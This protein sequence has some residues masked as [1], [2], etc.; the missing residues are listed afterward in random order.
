MASKRQDLCPNTQQK[1]LA[2]LKP[3]G[4]T[5]SEDE[6]CPYCVFLIGAHNL[7]APPPQQQAGG[8]GWLRDLTCEGVEAN[9]GPCQD[10][11]AV[12]PCK[13]SLTK[14]DLVAA[15]QPAVGGTCPDC[16]HKVSLHSSAAPGGAAGGAGAGAGVS[17]FFSSLRSIFSRSTAPSPALTA[18]VAAAPPPF[19]R[20]RDYW[21]RCGRIETKLQASDEWS[22]DGQC[23]VVHPQLLLTA[24][25]VLF[26]ETGDDNSLPPAKAAR[27]DAAAATASS[28]AAASS[29]SESTPAT[30]A[31]ADPR[32]SSQYA[33]FPYIRAVFV[34]PK[35]VQGRVV[36]RTQYFFE[37]EAPPIRY[38]DSMD[39]AL[40][41]I[42]V[43]H[44]TVSLL[45]FGRLTP[46][47]E[48]LP[49]CSVELVTFKNPLAF[50]PHEI[51]GNVLYV[52]ERTKKHGSGG[53]FTIGE[54][55]YLVQGG[56]SGGAVVRLAADGVWELVGVH[57]GT[58]FTRYGDA[59]VRAEQGRKRKGVAPV[60]SSASTTSRRHRSSRSA[61]SSR[62]T[63]GTVSY[64]PSDEDGPTEVP[65]E[66]SGDALQHAQTH[67]AR[68][69]F[70]VA[71]CV[72]AREHWRIPYVLSFPPV[73]A[74][75]AVLDSSPPRG[76]RGGNS[77]RRQGPCASIPEEA[78]GPE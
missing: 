40:L 71:E 29:A 49:R 64:D 3:D 65:A 2:K 36:G 6:E 37:C 12:A 34:E 7:D 23:V 44:P 47:Q 43:P 68:A 76:R 32:H 16:G 66:E 8:G 48:V 70:F 27:A 5:R 14:E 45:P 39:A 10:G 25:H 61:S 55:D 11:P 74:D 73:A 22:S 56:F 72:L 1:L 19:T 28:A 53:Q 9:P 31:R 38:S 57:T 51:P 62:A 41:R 78:A 54:T 4:S 60:R 42:K 75:S 30:S 63:D 46:A 15:G 13:C 35:I 21:R 77:A 58:D 18:A 26:Y 67:S 24:A 17:A 52:E 69:T 59:A 20:S 33:P 50:T